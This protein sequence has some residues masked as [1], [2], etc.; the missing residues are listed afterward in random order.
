[1]GRFLDFLVRVG[2]H[3]Y[4]CQRPVLAFL[5]PRIFDSADEETTESNSENISTIET[6]KTLE[7]RTKSPGYTLR[8]SLTS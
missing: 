4:Q 1:M 6:L 3:D 5:Y 8:F 2:E 7:A